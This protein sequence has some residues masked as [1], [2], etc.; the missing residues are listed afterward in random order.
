MLRT[1]VLTCAT[2][3]LGFSSVHAQPVVDV[4]ANAATAAVNES[5]KLINLFGYQRSVVPLDG[6]YAINR[7]GDI[8]GKRGG[9]AAVYTQGNVVILPG[10]V[11]Y[12]NLQAVDI[13]DNGY[14]VGN[15]LSAGATRPLFW[16]SMTSQ[17]LDMSALGRITVPTAINS[18]G[19][20]VGYYYQGSTDDYPRAFRW[21]MATGMADIAP[22][23]TSV[24]QAFDISETGY[25]AGMAFYQS[26][27]QQVVRWYPNGAVGRITGPGFAEGTLA[28]GSVYGYTTLWD[29]KN[30]AT[31]IGP[32]T[33]THAVKRIS[34][35]NRMVGFTL[36]EANGPRAW[37]TFNN[38]AALYLPVP[39]GAIG[40]AND[41]NACGTI[42]GSIR[43]SDGTE[44][45]VTW[46]KLTCDLLPPVITAQ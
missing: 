33:A 16:A 39:A 36:G 41:V 42:L 46:S 11:G 43:L 31:P 38:S 14:I 24:S 28:N 3:I 7:A 40:F 15:G 4:R 5:G 32:N 2:A 6:A 18:Q 13:A 26:I 34:R 27:G 37:T 30:T 25:I 20:V 17:P 12:T 8:A 10:K 1:A 9:N 23:T 19:V 45:W 44:Q 35:T 29:L 21:S 22:A